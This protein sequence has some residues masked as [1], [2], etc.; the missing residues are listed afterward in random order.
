MFK[1][2]QLS[3]YYILVFLL[4]KK[5]K[6]LQSRCIRKA[7]SITAKFELKPPPYPLVR[8]KVCPLLLLLPIRINCVRIQ[9]QDIGFEVHIDNEILVWGL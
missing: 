5:K 2:F 9:L 6:K 4:I 8:S 1:I 7:G 3:C